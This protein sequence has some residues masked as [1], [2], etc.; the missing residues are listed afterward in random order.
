MTDAARINQLV[1]HAVNEEQPA[2][3]PPMARGP[4]TQ[5]PTPAVGGGPQP[6]AGV[7]AGGAATPGEEMLPG[8]QQTQQITAPRTGQITPIR[9][10]AQAD[11]E[12]DRIIQYFAQGGPTEIDSTP[13]PSGAKPTLSQSIKG[14]NAGIAGLERGVRDVPE[15]TQQFVAQEQ[16]NIKARNQVAEGIIGDR[17]A[18]NV[19]EAQL[20]AETGPQKNAVFA[21]TTPT[22][23]SAAVAK[24]DAILASEK[25]QVDAIRG[26]L[27]KVR[28]QLVN[29]DG[30]MQ[31][32]PLQLYG[33]DRNIRYMTGPKAAGTA[34]DG[35]AA[36][37]ELGQV[38]DALR[39][40]I[41][42]G[43]PGFTD[44]MANQ[45]ARRSEIDGERWLQ[46]RNITDAHGN[47]NLQK[48]DT[49]I[50]T[51]EN[52]QALPGK[53]LADGVT[54]EQLAKLKALQAEYQNDAKQR[55]GVSIGSPTV[56]KLGVSGAA[57]MLGH[58]LLSGAVGAAGAYTAGVNPLL[59]LLSAAGSYA[60]KA[61]DARGQRLVMDALRNKLLNPELARGA[62]STGTRTPPPNPLTQPPP[63]P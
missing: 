45:A 31:T 24:I 6:S 51:L 32:D 27:E 46:S 13:L 3:G 4:T 2:V 39:P 56:Q 36:A 61:A 30:N 55:L 63:S 62:F 60:F 34:A 26:P 17:D 15:Q 25:G 5:K 35:R 29:K 44:Y 7:P 19:K 9:N 37:Y 28:T 52:Q 38:V 53:R 43:A 59:G 50:K 23:P 40:S 20:D 47:V 22:D 42:A 12:A 10:A 1:E 14:G 18:T 8:P 49:T 11:A 33:I 41:E 54:P 21:N 16:A 57:G 58:P 48:L